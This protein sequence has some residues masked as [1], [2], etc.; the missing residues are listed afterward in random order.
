MSFWEAAPN[1][2]GLEV[3]SLSF[4]GAAP[5]REGL[6][7]ILSMLFWQQLQIVKG[8]GG[9]TL[10][11]GSGWGPILVVVGGAGLHRAGLGWA[12]PRSFGVAG[13][14]LG[15][16]E[17]GTKLFWA[18]R[19]ANPAQPPAQLPLVKINAR[20][21]N[22]TRR[23]SLKSRSTSTR[24]ETPCPVGISL[25]PL[26]YHF[27]HPVAKPWYVLLLRDFVV[28]VVDEGVQDVCVCVCVCG[29]LLRRV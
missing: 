18:G 14:G 28:V 5:N 27:L 12:H 22:R 9:T 8:C 1:R 2:E 21:G 3:L 16:G 25:V 13:F 7:G 20:R 23:L 4:W 24:L 26:L 15:R 17:L 6:V 11:T 19:S 29:R 10:V